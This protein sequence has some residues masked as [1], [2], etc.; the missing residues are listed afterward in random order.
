M[1]VALALLLAGCLCVERAF[2]L[3]CW[4]CDGA[5]SNWG[6]WKWQICSSDDN[7]CA[8]TYVGGGIGEYS[9]QSISK[10]CV[11]VCPQGGINIGIAAASV[12]CCSSFLC[13]ISGASSV[14]A[15]HLVLAA[16]ILASF[17]YLFRHRL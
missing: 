14:Q 7:Y 16:S 2:S 4:S 6:C 11:P 13:N 9:S 10:G 15:N 1:K 12:K 8:T 3:V 5:E 17:L